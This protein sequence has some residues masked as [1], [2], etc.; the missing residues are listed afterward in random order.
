[1]EEK[2]IDGG[3]RMADGG[4]RKDANGMTPCTTHDPPPTT[5][6]FSAALALAAS[7]ALA[8]CDYL[9]W[10]YTPIKDIVAQPGPFDGKE[11]RIK[12]KARDPVQ[13]LEL[14]MFVVA[15]ETGEIR[16]STAGAVPS[17]GGDV[18]VKGVVRSAVIIGGKSVGLHLQ[19][20]ERIR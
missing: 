17:P 13:F 20:T 8:G 1:L 19:E 18:A 5:H 10:A 14:K 3:W 4:W 9:P 11:V 15:D 12:G 2:K 6:A 7:L 16:V